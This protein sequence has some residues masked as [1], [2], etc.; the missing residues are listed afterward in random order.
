MVDGR[1]IGKSAGLL[2]KKIQSHFRALTET[3]GTM[4]P[5]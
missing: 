3:E 1:E 2:T 5:R 4:I